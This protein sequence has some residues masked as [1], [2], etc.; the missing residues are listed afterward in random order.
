MMRVVIVGGGIAGLSAAYFLERAMAPGGGPVEIFLVERASRLGGKIL[1]LREEGFIGEGG[2]DSFLRAKP[3]GMALLRALGLESE[4]VPPRARAVYVLRRGRLHPIPEALLALRP[5]PMA[6]LRAGGLPWRGRLRALLEP[7]VPPR[8]EDGDEP[9]AAFLRRRFGRAFAEAIAEPLTAGVHAGDPERLSAQALYPHLLALERRF[10]SLARGLRAARPAAPSGPAFV[11]LRAG[12][13]ALVDRLAASLQRTRIL[14]GRAVIGLAPRR[15]GPAFRYLAAMADGETLEADGV[16]LA[17]PAFE[18]ARWLAP[19]APEAAARLR[20]I[21]FVSTT[22]ITLAFRREQV[23]HPLNGSGF[24]VPRGEAFPLAGCTWTSS[25]WP[26]RA[27]EGCVL[28]RAFIGRAGDADA[29]ALEDPE[30]IRMA[31]EALRPLLGLQGSPLRA[32]VHRW[33][34]GM[35]QYTVGHLERLAAIEAALRPFPR[36]C[37]IGASYRGVGIPDLIRQAREA[38]RLLLGEEMGPSGPPR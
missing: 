13:E 4:A 18:A 5:D 30:L 26:G 10:G 38:V 11:S 7:W 36:L 32:W 34:E 27:S 25:K 17:V 22:V 16:V 12:M 21:P 24:L 8:R 33:P 15:E 35:P 20:E 19:F 3:E 2:P 9:L 6:V 14:T 37:L 29:L 28:L 23:A 1:T 31:V